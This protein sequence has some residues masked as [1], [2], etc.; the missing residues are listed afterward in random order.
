[1]VEKFLFSEFPDSEFEKLA[2]LLCGV[3]NTSPS[4]IYSFYK[5]IKDTFGENGWPAH[6]IDDRAFFC[7]SDEEFQLTY[8]Q[9][10]SVAVDLPSTF[11]IDDG[12][13]LKK[14]VVILGQ[15]SKSD[16][17]TSKIHLGT[18]Y[19]LHH[20][21]SREV[22]TRTKVY[23]EMICALMERGYRVYLTDVYKIWVCNPQR[24]FNGA[25]LP[26]ADKKDFIRILKSELLN[27]NPVALVAWGNQAAHDVQALDL[28]KAL[29]PGVEYLEFPHPS[30]AANGAWKKRLGGEKSTNENKIKYF[31]S[32]ISEKLPLVCGT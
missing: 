11:E 14:T 31:A 22:L 32:V 17:A 4:Q 26:R 28:L 24:P 6:H 30:G 20:K 1:M 2:Q 16:Q 18:P 9:S 21:A 27:V 23:F 12:V 13:A 10:P 7:S 15:D 8:N 25:S 5:E 29:E 19:G 3:F